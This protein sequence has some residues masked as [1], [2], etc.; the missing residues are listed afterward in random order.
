M[1][2]AKVLSL[3]AFTLA[4]LAPGGTAQAQEERS[5]VVAVL[6]YGTTVEEIGATPELVPGIVSAGL[7]GVP[8]TQTLLDISQGNRVNEA[9]YDGELPPLRIDDGRVPPSAWARVVERA[10]AA[11]ADVI[12]GLL[13]S[14]LIAAG[15]DVTA[16]DAVGLPALIGVDREGE[17]AVADVGSCAPSCGSGLSLIDASADELPQIVA[18][19]D[20][21]GADV[22][23]A[24]AAG[25]RGEQQ[26]LPIGI[27]GEGF[28]GDL[29]S[30]STR[31][32]GLVTTSDLAPTILG[33]FGVRIPDEVNGSEITSGDQR[34]PAEV[35]DLQDRLDERPSRD[36]VVLLPFAIWLLAAVLA[37]L[38]WRGRGARVALRLLGLA[39][40]S[41]PLLL[42]VAAAFDA[43]AAASALLFGVGSLAVAAIV[44]RLVPGFGAF[45]LAGGATVAAYAVDVVVGSPL[46]AY[47][48]LGPNPGYGVRFFGIGNELEAILAPLALIATGAGLAATGRTGRTAALWFAGVALLAAAAFAPGRFGADVG[49]AIVLGVG[50]ASAVALSLGLDRRRT[51]LLVVGAGVAGL[52]ALLVVDQLLGGAHLSRTVLGAGEASDLIDVLERRVDLMLDT[53]TDPVYPELLVIA[54]ALLIAG[55]ARRDA[56][57]GWFGDGPA[58][59]GFLGALAGVLVGTVAN[60]SGSVLLVL[61]TICLATSAGFFWA[62]QASESARES[63]NGG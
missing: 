8:F 38:A 40:A 10:E 34:D 15:V 63:P 37:S 33:A 16:E 60:D 43:G 48:V 22:L 21:E 54:A 5:V 47:S 12:P 52:V 57:L 3:V 49:A 42:L 17:I 44:G 31:T 51:A 50:G 28:D 59:A 46:T 11:P 30:S 55:F 25:A 6:P 56:V 45:A 36:T 24:L 41:G 20:L 7:G 26:L 18:G 39:V 27:A 9:L 13:A 4:M 23:I 62:S 19:L 14:S 32:D 2:L 61:G 58:R 29:T 53:F 1:N 35:A